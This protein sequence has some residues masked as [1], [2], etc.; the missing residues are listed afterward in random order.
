MG[1]FFM[2]HMCTIGPD[3]PPAYVI[4]AWFKHNPPASIQPC[5][6]AL[7]EYHVSRCELPWYC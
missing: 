2:H 4:Q 7:L 1:S 3:V 5:L 6:R